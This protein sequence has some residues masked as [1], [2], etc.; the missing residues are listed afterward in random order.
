MNPLA[1]SIEEL[2]PLRVADSMWCFILL[3][4]TLVVSS[5]CV[6]FLIPFFGTYI[7]LS[8]STEK[9]LLT[10]LEKLNCVIYWVGLIA[11]LVMALIGSLLSILVVSKLSLLVKK[12]NIRI[13][14]SFNVPKHISLYQ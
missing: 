11:G 2:L 6:A 5:V 7:R 1:R 14:Y 13:K 8:L 9:Y 3:R 4:T 10:I 12:I